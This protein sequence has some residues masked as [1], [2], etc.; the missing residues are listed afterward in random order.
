MIDLRVEGDRLRVEIS[1]F[2]AFMIAWRPRWS[3]AE[4]LDRVRRIS[5]VP[6][7]REMARFRYK[8]ARHGDLVCRHRGAPA[9]VIDLEGGGYRRLT[10]SVRDPDRAA[11]EIQAAVPTN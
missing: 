2:D 7:G 6:S 5:V 1:G 10:L 4:P 9:L 11:A 8:R 3:H